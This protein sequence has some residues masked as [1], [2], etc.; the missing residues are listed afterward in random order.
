[1]KLYIGLIAGVD[2]INLHILGWLFCSVFQIMLILGFYKDVF[3]YKMKT[4]VFV[5]LCCISVKQVNLT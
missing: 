1:L 5:V 3:A 4:I 2:F